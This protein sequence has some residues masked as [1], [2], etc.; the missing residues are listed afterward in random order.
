MAQSFVR[1][2]VAAV[3]KSAEGK[4]LVG[5]R[6][7]SS[8]GTWQFPGGH[9]EMGETPFACAERETLEETGVDVKA[10]KLIGLTNDIFDPESK[11]YITLFVSCRMIDQTQQP[12]T[13][14]PEKCEGWSWKEWSDIKQLVSTEAGREKV[15]LPI[16]NLINEQPSL[17]L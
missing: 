3:I 4:L 12:K 5:I 17:E 10:E 15:F 13:M 16:I 8:G 11:H 1:V 6:K 7:G 14:E 9:L 2:G